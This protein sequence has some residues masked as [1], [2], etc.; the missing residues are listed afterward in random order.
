MFASSAPH[1]SQY[2]SF[3]LFIVPHSAHLSVF[4]TPADDEVRSVSGESLV[5]CTLGAAG[6]AGFSSAAFSAGFSRPGRV[7]TAGAARDGVFTAAGAGVGVTRLAPDEGSAIR[8]LLERDESAA[9]PAPG[10]V[11]ETDGVGT[12][13]T[14]LRNSSSLKSVE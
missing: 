13:T 3:G 8:S 9:L 6:A 7:G 12:P 4:S 11:D 10:G 2:H 14:D 5:T 1:F